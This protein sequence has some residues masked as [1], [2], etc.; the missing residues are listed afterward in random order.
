[1]GRWLFVFLSVGF[2]AL[3]LLAAPVFA[4]QVQWNGIF[5]SPEE[6]A[7]YEYEYQQSNPPAEGGE[8]LLEPQFG[9]QDLISYS[10]GPCDANFRNTSYPY[11]AI[12]C[13]A[14]TVPGASGT[15]SVGYPI[16]LPTGAEIVFVWVYYYDTHTG[17]EPSMGFWTSNNTGGTASVLLLTPSAYSGGNRGLLFGPISHTVNNLSNSYVI[18]AIIDQSATLGEERLYRFVVRYRLQ[19][20]PPPPLPTFSD[21]PASH[22]FYQA[23]EALVASGI[24]SGCGGGLYCPNAP[25]T[26][27]QMAAFLAKALGLHYPN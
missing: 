18:L 2:A 15:A 24:T 19:V 21:V 4:E 3:T 25:V 9:T 11:E 10:V 8:E 1:M 20:S 17:S 23:I 14:V 27:G 12:N 6:I 7:N 26:R 5:A 22:Q 13:D 16:H